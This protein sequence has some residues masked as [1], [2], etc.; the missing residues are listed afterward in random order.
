M[1][2][3]LQPK[4]APAEGQEATAYD[5]ALA[6]TEGSVAAYWRPSKDSYL[7]RITRE[8]LLALARETLGESWAQARRS[9]KKA[10]LVEQIDRA[11][12]DPAKYGRTPEQI[13]KLKTW[14]PAGMA[15]GGASPE[16]AKAKKPRKPRNHQPGGQ[17]CPPVIRCHQA[18][19]W[20]RKTP[21]AVARNRSK[22]SG[23][24]RQICVQARKHLFNQGNS[25]FPMPQARGE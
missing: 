13:E 23:E 18:V 17:R 22:Y 7:S 2:L 6:Q 3:T 19:A 16:A 5:A 1:A 10:S 4:L 11:F 24:Q 9:D 14:L 12:A 25:S 8:Q 15:F 20:V 21:S